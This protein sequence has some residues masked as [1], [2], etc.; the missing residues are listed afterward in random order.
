MFQNYDVSNLSS[1]SD[2][3]KVCHFENILNFDIKT[4]NTINNYVSI[5]YYNYKIENML[6]LVM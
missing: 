5:L 4:L 3:I 2:L 1:K 6:F